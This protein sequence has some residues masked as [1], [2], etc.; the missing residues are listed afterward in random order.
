M[1]A[2]TS[3]ADQVT[4]SDAATMAVV[5]VD[6]PL[7]VTIDGENLRVARPDPQLLG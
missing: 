3:L 5:P 1:M 7:E 4:F 2:V 6:T